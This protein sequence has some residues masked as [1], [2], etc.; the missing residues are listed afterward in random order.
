M[1]DRLLRW[2]PVAV[3]PYANADGLHG[4]I[5]WLGYDHDA[6]RW[7]V[8]DYKTAASWG[9]WPLDGAGHEIE[10]A[11]YNL[12]A[13]LGRALPSD[14][15]A[16]MEWHVAKTS[17]GKTARFEPARVVRFEVDEAH[18]RWLSFERDRA[19]TVVGTGAFEQ[20]PAWN[21]CSAKWCAF[22]EGCQ[23]T[24]E[25]APGGAALPTA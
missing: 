17:R 21:L 3:E 22:W 1:R 6:G 19:D 23:V 25:L 16:V 10:A 11:V 18:R 8:V 2:R 5:D 4:Y 12:L 20:N 13:E 9:R 14:R 15:D 24:G 7:V